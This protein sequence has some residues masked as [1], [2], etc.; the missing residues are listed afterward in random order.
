MYYCIH[1]SEH[2]YRFVPQSYT[3]RAARP[4]DVHCA[5]DDGGG[6]LCRTDG[7]MLVQAVY[8]LL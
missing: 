5:G 6:S 3:A 2:S 7:R 1:N 4:D 8:V